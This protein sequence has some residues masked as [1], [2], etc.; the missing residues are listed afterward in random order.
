MLCVNRFLGPFLWS[1]SVLFP[2][3][4]LCSCCCLLSSLFPF[5][6]L[7]SFCIFPRICFLQPP[8]F[9]SPA[10]GIWSYTATAGSFVIFGRVLPALCFGWLKLCES[11]GS[12]LRMVSIAAVPCVVPGYGLGTFSL[13]SCCLC[14]PNSEQFFQLFA[15]FH[16][17]RVETGHVSSIQCR[18]KEVVV[19]L[20][21]SN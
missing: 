7:P 17:L 6:W 5:P 20:T 21:K 12:Q 2:A 13:K 3:L 4:W 1:P 15:K 11:I 9:S 19:S 10:E 16:S 8:S 18:S 14:W